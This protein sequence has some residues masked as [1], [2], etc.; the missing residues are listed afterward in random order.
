MHVKGYAAPETKAAEERAR[1]L[2]EHAEAIGE[3]PEDPLL[4][5]SV[6]YGFWVASYVAFNGD[7]LRELASQFLAL[8]EKQG[9]TVPLMIG[10]RL[11]GVS[12]TAT[13]SIV[14]G[15]AHFD[16]ALALYDA[17]EHRPLATQFGQDVRAAILSY[18]P[19][20][21]W[22][23]GYPDAALTDT[24]HALK[25]AREIGQAPTLMYALTWTSFSQLF[26]GKY[27]AANALNDELVTLA[28]EK[29]SLYWKSCGTALKG[30]ALAMNG[31]ASNAVEML[32]S[33]ITAARSTGATTL[34]PFYLSHLAKAYEELGQLDDAWRCIGEAMT[35][36][37]TT[38]EKW[39]EA[40]VNR[41]AGQIALMSREADTVR[42]EAY[43]DAALTVAR[44]QQAKSLELRAA[45]SLARLWRDQGKP[46]QAR[47]L[48]APVY[49]WFTEGFDTLDLKEAKALLD[50]LHA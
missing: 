38:N 30:T 28:D 21:L 27:A 22:L 46:Q 15:R 36:V 18:R 29:K 40:E 35:A 12:L 19:L 10:H 49:G 20:A 47:E 31:K 45:M 6:L 39:F 33:G 32:S 48:L 25:D 50:E 17:A 37:G 3:P 1:V 9:T 5:F 43:F 16:R 2:I 23:L 14:Q 26:C 44:A 42:A 11:T 8:A 13:G 24:E 4:L 41:S 7:A 34:V